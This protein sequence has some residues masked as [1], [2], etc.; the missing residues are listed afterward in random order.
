MFTLKWCAKHSLL[1][2]S[3]E[4]LLESIFL[5]KWAHALSIRELLIAYANK[6][7]RIYEYHQV[8]IL[9][10]L[11]IVILNREEGPSFVLRFLNILDIVKCCLEKS[12]YFSSSVV[13][14]FTHLPLSPEGS[15][16]LLGLIAFKSDEIFFI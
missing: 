4:I 2:M 12:Q 11:D 1:Y 6:T 16:N 5:L 7:D 9:G 3:V 15:F 14:R 10:N 13:A 8:W